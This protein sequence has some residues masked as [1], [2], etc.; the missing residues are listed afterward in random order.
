MLAWLNGE[1]IVS[2]DKCSTCKYCVYCDSTMAQIATECQRYESLDSAPAYEWNLY[3][4]MK[5][6]IRVEDGVPTE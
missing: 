5:L 4:L 1:A 6:W 2:L 3:D